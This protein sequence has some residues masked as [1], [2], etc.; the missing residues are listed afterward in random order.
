MK[1]KDIHSVALEPFNLRVYPIM[2]GDK[3]HVFKHQEYCSGCTFVKILIQ[4]ISV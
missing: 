4:N 1:L 2:A 3:K